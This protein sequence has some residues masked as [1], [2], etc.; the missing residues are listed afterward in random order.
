M[1]DIFGT[2]VKGGGSVL[3]EKKREL[4]SAGGRDQSSRVLLNRQLSGHYTVGRACPLSLSLPSEGHYTHSHMPV[5]VRG[6]LNSHISCFSPHFYDSCYF[7][8]YLCHC[9]DVS[10]CAR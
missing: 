10:S 5:H 2:E 8:F 4:A 6:L 3:A 7:F 1:L 9:H